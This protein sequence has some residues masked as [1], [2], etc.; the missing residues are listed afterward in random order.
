VTLRVS[1]G[2]W[3]SLRNPGY[4]WA[5]KRLKHLQW[6]GL[7]WVG[8]LVSRGGLATHQ[9]LLGPGLLLF[10][11][12]CL[13]QAGNVNGCQKP[14]T[15]RVHGPPLRRYRVIRTVQLETAWV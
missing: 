11:S 5:E 13:L 6:V 14:T 2:S 1:S 12:C 4:M 9:S 15:G 7:G 3:L 10:R 8:L